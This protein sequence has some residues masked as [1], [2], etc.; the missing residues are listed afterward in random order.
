MSALELKIPPVLL[1]LL[2]MAAAYVIP[3]IAP[4]AVSEFTSY[5]LSSVVSVLGLTVILMGVLAFKKHQTTVNPVTPQASSTLVTNSIYRFTRNPMYLGFA[6]LLLSWSL[7]LADGFLF[8]LV[9][10]FVSYLTR[11]QIIPEERV[12]T[13]L[14]GQPFQ[15]YCS[16]VRRWI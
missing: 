9:G 11:F 5:V 1:L 10:L 8:V 13:Q 6:L 14:F 2:F 7:W 3:P 4:L 15:H 16:K 12:L